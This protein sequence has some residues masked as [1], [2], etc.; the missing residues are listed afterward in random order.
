MG[1]DNPVIGPT[2]GGLRPLVTTLRRKLMRTGMCSGGV[3]VFPV[4]S[5]GADRARNSTRPLLFRLAL[6]TL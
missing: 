3:A 1:G 5:W 6:V 2:D 4:W